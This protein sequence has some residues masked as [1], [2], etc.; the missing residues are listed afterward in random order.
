MRGLRDPGNSKNRYVGIWYSKTSDQTVVWTANR[1]NQVGNSSGVL[2]I[3]GGNLVLIDGGHNNNNIIL[4]STDV[5]SST[6]ANYSSATH[7]FWRATAPFKEGSDSIW[8]SGPWN[9]ERLGGVPLTNR[10]TT[11]DSW[12]YVANDDEIYLTYKGTN[13]SITSMSFLEHSGLLQRLMWNDNNRRWN[14]ILLATQDRCDG[15]ATCGAYA[16]CNS[17][18]VAWCDCLRGFKPKTPSDWKL[19]D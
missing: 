16:S 17:N 1:E 13:S 7:R 10:S 12:S 14:Q 6:M 3:I 8:R 5:S 2:T 19:R 4:W 9:G 15:Y 11:A 18:H